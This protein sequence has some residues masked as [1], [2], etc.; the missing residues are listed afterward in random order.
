[1]GQ[2]AP[3]LGLGR[4]EDG[5]EDQVRHIM[6]KRDLGLNRSTGRIGVLLPDHIVDFGISVI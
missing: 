5:L 4:L 2:K 3:E 1:M 6:K